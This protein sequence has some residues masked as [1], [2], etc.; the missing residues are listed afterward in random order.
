M[1]IMVAMSPCALVISTP[2][3]ILSGIANGAR[4]GVLFKGGV[5]LEQAAVIKGV[6]FDKT[7]TLTEGK[8][9]VTDVVVHDDRRPPLEALGAGGHGRASGGGRRPA[10]TR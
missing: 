7:G 9:K 10:T 3:S 8:P 1:T 4:R 2:A 5:H 6:A